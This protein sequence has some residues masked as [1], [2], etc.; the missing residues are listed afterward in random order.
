MPPRGKEIK[1]KHGLDVQGII[2]VNV[3]VLN[4]TSNNL[5]V[6]SQVDLIS[7]KV[8]YNWYVEK[9]NFVLIRPN[10]VRSFLPQLDFKDNLFLDKA[11]LRILFTYK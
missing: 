4:G 5:I 11:K 9:E 6:R 8:L 2:G 10:N 1:V 7:Q 3:T